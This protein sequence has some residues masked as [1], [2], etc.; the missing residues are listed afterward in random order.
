MSSSVVSALGVVDVQQRSQEAARRHV[1]ELGLRLHGVVQPRQLAH[2]V[3]LLVVLDAVRYL[4]HLV[5]AERLAVEQHLHDAGAR[6]QRAVRG[7]RL[8]QRELH[9][10]RVA[11]RRVALDVVCG[12]IGVALVVDRRAVRKPYLVH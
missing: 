2:R 4:A 9:V 8:G 11:L 5:E 3:D 12:V 6:G 10:T 1:V 7:V